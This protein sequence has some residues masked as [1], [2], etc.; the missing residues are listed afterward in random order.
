MR[1]PPHHLLPGILLLLAATASAAGELAGSVSLDH[2]TAEP[3][4]RVRDTVIWLEQVPEK[5]EQKLTRTPYH[6]FWKRRPPPPPLARAVQS[7]RCYH[8]HVIAL[9]AGSAMV[10][11]NEDSVWHAPF[12]VSPARGFDLGKLEP[13]RA[14]TVA[15]D[16]TGVVAVRCAIFP[17]MSMFVVV[18]PNHAFTRPDSAGTWRLPE[19]PAGHYVVHAWHPVRGDYRHEV[20]LPAHGSVSLPLRW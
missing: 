14:D 7:G 8:P 10:I 20:D 2:S 17:D 3:R 5:T 16:S 1:P 15:F 19:L 18:T 4:T 12:S 11:S 13:G 6:W 9:A